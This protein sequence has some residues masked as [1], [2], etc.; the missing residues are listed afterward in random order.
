QCVRTSIRLFLAIIDIGEKLRPTNFDPSEQAELASLK[1][2]GKMLDALVQPFIDRHM[3]LS[4]QASSLIKFLHLLCGLYLTNGT[5]FMNNQLYGDLQAMV[6]NALLMIPKTRLI[7]GQLKVFICLLGDDV[8]ESLF[9]RCRMIGGHLPN[10]SVC[11][12]RD[13]FSSAMN[14]DFIYERHP[15]FERKPRRLTLLCSRDLD[16]LRPW[17][18][19][20]EITASS[21]DLETCWAPADQGRRVD[22]AGMWCQNALYFC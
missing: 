19:E 1:V 10:C 17:E 9:G 22:A 6:K 18:W 4:K 20:G 15:E 11:Q 3:S 5:A 16:H 7:D 8:L 12:L 21:C 13:R 2:L 14:L